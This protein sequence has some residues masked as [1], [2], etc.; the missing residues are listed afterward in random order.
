[1]KTGTGR[2]RAITWCDERS[3]PSRTTHG[4][5]PTPSR[6]S[7]AR[8]ELPR[9]TLRGAL[10]ITGELRTSLAFRILRMSILRIINEYEK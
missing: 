9:L 8:G 4:L 5:R 1:M 10:H 2:N 7:T 6:H 3:I